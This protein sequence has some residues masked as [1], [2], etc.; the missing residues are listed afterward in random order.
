MAF[1]ERCVCMHVLKWWLFEVLVNCGVC[2]LVWCNVWVTWFSLQ[3]TLGWIPPLH[4]KLKTST[5]STTCFFPEVSSCFAFLVDG[6]WW[7]R[8]VFLTQRHWCVVRPWD[9]LHSE[10]KEA[11]EIALSSEGN[12]VRL[13][14]EVNIYLI[15]FLRIC[16]AA[17]S[18]LSD[19]FFGNRLCV[20]S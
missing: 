16:F 7:I 19:N 18:L 8:S 1:K 9:N 20:H 6:T 11:S 2:L 13:M 17:F 12:E 14:C 15:Y 3:F 5:E 4:I 10:K